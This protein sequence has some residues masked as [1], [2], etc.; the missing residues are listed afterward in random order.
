MDGR[1]RAGRRRQRSHLGQHEERIGL[2]TPEHLAH[3]QLPGSGHVDRVGAAAGRL[4]GAG[5][6]V[7]N[8]LPAQRRAPRGFG[9][10]DATLG[11]ASHA[12]VGSACGNDID[13]GVAI[14]GTTVYLPC[15][16][17]IIAVRVTR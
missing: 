15:T 5:W 8:R 2:F 12:R 1:R 10:Q 11:D 3:Q 17:E 13:G 6:E 7:P 16:T 4:G 9:H 14:D